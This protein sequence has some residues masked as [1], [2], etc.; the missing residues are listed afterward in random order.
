MAKEKL[1]DQIYKKISQKIELTP[2]TDFA[3]LQTIHT[4]DGRHAGSIKAFTGHK[5]EKFSIAE[6]SIAPEMDYINTSLKPTANYAIPRFSVNFM[7]ISGQIQFDVDLYPDLDLTV[8]Q[9]YIDKYYEQLT[10][11]Y[12]KEKNAP[13]FNWKLSDR[14]WVRV[15]ASPYFFMSAADMEHE[16]KVHN[17]IHVYLDL[18]LK[19]WQ[20]EKEVSGAEA[21]QI[22][23]RRNYIL[24]MLLERE[25]ERH[26]LE[27]AF[28]KEIAARL[29]DAMV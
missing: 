18:W 2:V 22:A 20:E 3:D 14:S 25:P 12:L 27:K 29:G 19:I 5:I 7:V 9:D 11:I 28:G 24:N 8:R 23:T 17:L 21:E 15:S 26:I 13:Y 16:D 10:D 4:L 1:S 6:L